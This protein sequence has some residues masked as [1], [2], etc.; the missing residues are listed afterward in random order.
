MLAFASLRCVVCFDLVVCGC[1]FDFV[2]CLICLVCIGFVLLGGRLIV[3]VYAYFNGLL[4]ICFLFNCFV[5]FAVAGCCWLLFC[6]CLLA[7]CGVLI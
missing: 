5:C 6:Y 7:C 1:L 4:C 3:L 2:V